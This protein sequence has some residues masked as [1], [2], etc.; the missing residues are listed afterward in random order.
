MHRR[1]WVLIGVL[2]ALWGAS[3]LF[4]KV[5]LDDGFTPA[6]VVWLRTALALAVLAP[7]AVHRRALGALRGT[8]AVLGW[9]VALA[10]IQVVVPFLLITVSEL[11]I[12]SSLAAILVSAAPIFTA[13]LALRV[14]PDER[15]TGWRA[16][17]IVVGIAGV[18][19]L[20]GVDLTG[21]LE[22]ALGGLAVLLAAL[23][24]AVGPL[25]SK[26]RIAPAGLQ[27]VAIVTATMAVSTLVLAPVLPFTGVSDGGL[28]LDAAGA[29]LTLG[30]GGTGIAFLI[31]YTLIADVGPAR[32]SLVAY[33]APGFSIVYGAT[34]LD[35]A[36]TVAT[37][38]GLLLILAGSYLGAEGRLPWAGRPVEPCGELSEIGGEEAALVAS[39][40]HERS[41]PGRAARPHR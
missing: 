4:I 35:E 38:A 32:A 28:S 30:L 41:R 34:L 14:D 12:S 17:G 31:F 9:I 19:L 13:L 5:A 29:L 7:V 21:D 3:Y 24:Y 23:G 40:G 10:L 33:I 37:I 25:M 18:A 39:E 22:E 15:S 6:A 16:V 27:P 2:A 20:F 26:H 36:V 1:A 8:P 11:H